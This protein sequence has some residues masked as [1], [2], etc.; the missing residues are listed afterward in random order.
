MTLRVEATV[1]DYFNHGYA[2]S[3]KWVCL[4]LSLADR[5]GE[6]VYAYID[7]KSDLCDTVGKLWTARPDRSVRR[8]TVQ[9]SSDAATAKTHQ[10]RLTGL[11]S[12]SWRLPDQTALRVASIR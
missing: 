6:T 3:S 11:V 4:R 5:P 1:D 7:R 8:L 9:I 10:V 12:G 2:D